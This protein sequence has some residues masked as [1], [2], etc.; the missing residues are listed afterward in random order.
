MITSNRIRSGYSKSL[1]AF[2]IVMMALTAGFAV[3]LI[4]VDFGLA[5]RVV[6]FIF[7]GFF[8]LLGAFL[9]L[10]MFFHYVV[11]EGDEIT[12]VIFFKKN[13]AKMKNISRIDSGPGF[14]QI[15]VDG[16]KFCSLNSEDRQTAAML[17][18]FERH[19]FDL[20]KIVKVKK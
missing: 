3:P 6:G 4:L 18:Q 12:N 14:Y 7:T 17:H 1:L 20:G 15:Y 9:V 10:D 16:R 2:L 8:F 5:F 13:R 11:V 19:G